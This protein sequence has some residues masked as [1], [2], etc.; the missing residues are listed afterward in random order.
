MR[1]CPRTKPP[2]AERSLVIQNR[3]SI[4]A[5]LPHAACATK[6]QV[7]SHGNP[8]FEVPHETRQFLTL[9]TNHQVNVVTHDYHRI[10]L[11]CFA[12]ILAAQLL[13]SRE[14]GAY[15]VLGDEF[16]FLESELRLRVWPAPIRAV[17]MRALPA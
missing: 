11:G 4:V 13:R 17:E 1:G 15:K 2:A 7:N 16:G 3:L 6:E 9:G 12:A 14:R 8:R 5:T 10:D